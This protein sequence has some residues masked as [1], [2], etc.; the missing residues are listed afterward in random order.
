MEH[1]LNSLRYSPSVS[2]C[3]FAHGTRGNFSQSFQ[4][5]YP[6]QTVRVTEQSQIGQIEVRAFLSLSLMIFGLVLQFGHWWGTWCANGRNLCLEFFF[7]NLH[8]LFCTLL[9]SS[10]MSVQ[11]APL[12]LGRNL[13]SL[14]RYLGKS[15][16]RG[17]RTEVLEFYCLPLSHSPD[18]NVCFL[19][20]RTIPLYDQ[21]HAWIPLILL[22]QYA[23]FFFVLF[24]CVFFCFFWIQ[25]ACI[26]YTMFEKE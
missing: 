25:S 13:Q 19:R 23:F 22:P 26:Y 21:L 10:S 3:T 2:L 17:R 12:H 14:L 18:R 1:S 20:A 11:R 5:V 8:K 6:Y 4:V 9:F 16:N 7:K 15:E 24:S